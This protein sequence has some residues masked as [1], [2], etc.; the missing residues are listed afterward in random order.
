[1]N[2][3]GYDSYDVNSYGPAYRSEDSAYTT[4]EWYDSGDEDQSALDALFF[5]ED[6][7]KNKEN[8]TERVV[9]DDIY[10]GDVKEIYVFS[11][12]GTPEGIYKMFKDKLESYSALVVFK[13]IDET[14]NVVATYVDEANDDYFAMKY[15]IKNEYKK[16]LKGNDIPILFD[17]D[18][19]NEEFFN[20]G[21]YHINYYA[22][23]MKGQNYEYKGNL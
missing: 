20:I 16:M 10:E 14:W 11:E 13:Y 1:M 3:Y 12:E 23:A 19:Y 18:N 5:M 7:M 6:K 15:Y 22:Q 8:N 21:N 17:E 4:D 9:M 2:G